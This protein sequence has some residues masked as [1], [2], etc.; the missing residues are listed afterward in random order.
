[1][2][3]LVAEGLGAAILPLLSCQRERSS[4]LVVARNLP[5][6]PQ[7]RFIDAA[8]R[9]GHSLPVIDEFLKTA[10]LYCSPAVSNA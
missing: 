7:R 9:P 8:R 6:F 2:K 1:M 10:R 5:A 4:G 3:M